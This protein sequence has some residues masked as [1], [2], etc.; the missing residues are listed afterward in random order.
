MTPLINLHN[1]VFALVQKLAGEWLIPTMARF[2]FVAVLLMY[3]W[4]SAVTKLGDGIF[5]I[6]SPSFG[7]YTQ[8]WPRAIEAAGYDLSAMS[9]FQWLVVVAGTA[10]EFILPLL[11]LLGLF[12]RLAAIGMIGFVFMQSLTDI[13][14]HHA[15]ATTIG[16]W[17]DRIHDSQIMDQR[18]FWMTILITLVLKGAGPLSLDRVLSG[19]STAA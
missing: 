6:F 18:L 5:G 4:N 1:F 14:G 2:A 12:T 10:A 15:D 13:F 8:I 19:K 3:F 7:G 16:S 9:W 17:F 11:I